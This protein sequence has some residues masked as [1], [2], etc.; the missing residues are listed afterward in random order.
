MTDRQAIV[1]RGRLAAVHAMGP[2][3]AILVTLHATS[4]MPDDPTHKFLA[5]QDD[6]LELLELVRELH[7]TLAE[8]PDPGGTSELQLRDCLQRRD[9]LANE[10]GHALMQVLATG[11]RVAPQAQDAGASRDEL[12]KQ[13]HCI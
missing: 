5:L 3:P 6:S 4:S 12:D 2:K 9:E 10:I 7:R 1:R 11:V 13:G 8:H